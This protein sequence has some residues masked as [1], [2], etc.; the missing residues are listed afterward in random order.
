MKKV[1]II[2]DSPSTPTGFSQVIHNIFK[3]LTNK[4]ELIQLGVNYFGDPHEIEWPIYPA[5]IRGDIWGFSR[6]PE[7]VAKKPDLIFILNDVWVIAKYLKEIKKAY[8]KQILP[9][10][11]VYFPV[12]SSEFDPEWFTDFDIVNRAVVYTKFGY[13]VVRTA[14]P[15]MELDIV[16]H[17]I[18]K[19]HFCK[20]F[21]TQEEKQALKKILYPDRED[22]YNSFIVLNRNRNQPR[23][24]I[25]ATIEGFAQFAKNKPE[26][27][28]LHLHM[29]L[30]DA[31]WDIAKLCRRFGVE[32][33][34]IVTNG[35]RQIQTVPVAKLNL[36]AN[37]SDVG[38]NTSFGEGWGLCNAE[39]ASVGVPQIVPDNSA[40]AELFRDIGLLIP[41]S[42]WTRQPDTMTLGGLVSA[43]GL[44]Q[45]LEELYQQPGLYANLALLS[46]EKFKNPIY[47]WENVSARFAT[48]FDGV[49]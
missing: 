36:I 31:G 16:P 5:S 8:D 19:K 43:D 7:L 27:V 46:E 45:N 1:L 25:D 29:G 49:L 47:D 2:A 33:R 32:E 13:D 41:V 42:L 6:I 40:S 24:K 10:I 23:K 39:D 37:A 12:D 18:N 20:L 48:I 11:V 44:A 9:N 17:G 21:R 14:V 35:T 3:N 34:L 28:K 4:Y 30:K 22:F 26:N 15:Q 38:V